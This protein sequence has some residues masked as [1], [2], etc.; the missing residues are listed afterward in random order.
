MHANFLSQCVLF[1]LYSYVHIWSV[2]Y[3]EHPHVELIVPCES[4]LLSTV[5]VQQAY[6]FHVRQSHLAKIINHPSSALE[7]TH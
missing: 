3:G 7:L 2:I 1:A 6:L 5:L 4:E